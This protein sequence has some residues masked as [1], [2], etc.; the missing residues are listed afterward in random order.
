MRFL[1]FG[2]V[3]GLGFRVFGLAECGAGSLFLSMTT[4]A[5]QEIA[6]S[7]CVGMKGKSSA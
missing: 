3:Q 5:L 2:A 7:P 6:I 4:K 1:G